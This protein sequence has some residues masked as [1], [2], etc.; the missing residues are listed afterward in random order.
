MLSTSLMQ[1][2]LNTTLLSNLPSPHS[3]EMSPFS[4]DRDAAVYFLTPIFSILDCESKGVI[5]AGDVDEH[6]NS[7]FFFNDRDQSRSIVEAEFLKARPDKTKRQSAFI[8][9]MMDTNKDNRVTP[10]EYREYVFYAIK[11]ADTNSDG[12]LF[13]KELLGNKFVDT[14][15]Q[16]L[17]N[18]HPNIAVK[19]SSNP[20]DNKHN[21]DS[22]IQPKQEHSHE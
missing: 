16:T 8:F 21:A 6:F 13:E 3:E 20:S 2:L 10:Q 11:T 14:P 9:K 7:L 22:T 4:Q 15:A 19:D 5:E 18:T 12:E 1:L 17:K